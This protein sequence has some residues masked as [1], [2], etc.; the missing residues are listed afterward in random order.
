MPM[1]RRRKTSDLGGFAFRCWTVA[2]V[3]DHGIGDPVISLGYSCFTSLFSAQTRS[4]A[5]V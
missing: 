5:Y 4:V 2:S 1:G 3:I